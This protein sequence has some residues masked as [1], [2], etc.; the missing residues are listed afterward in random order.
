VDLQQ[1]W[2][3]ECQQELQALQTEMQHVPWWHPRWVGLTQ[4]EQSL[5]QQHAEL[6]HRLQQMSAK[7][8][9][10]RPMVVASRTAPACSEFQEEDYDSD[11]YRSDT[12][13]E[14]QPEYAY[15][16]MD[17]MD[18]DMAGAAITNEYRI[19]STLSHGDEVLHED[20]CKIRH[21][22]ELQDQGPHVD[23]TSLHPDEPHEDSSASDGY[24]SDCDQAAYTNDIYDPISYEDYYN[25]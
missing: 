25:S 12:A 11:G 17:S 23:E 7:Q 19:T 5:Q 4:Q 20:V 3:D 16:M 8:S 18:H 22:V 13:N 1:R 15:N 14:Q 2:T 6:S 24:R 21:T 9:P 10:T